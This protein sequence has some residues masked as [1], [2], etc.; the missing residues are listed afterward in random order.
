VGDHATKDFHG[1]FPPHPDPCQGGGKFDSSAGWISD[2]AS[3]SMARK[4]DALS[5]TPQECFLWASTLQRDTE[6]Y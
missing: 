2:S 6:S 4:V 1:G 5:L 3:T